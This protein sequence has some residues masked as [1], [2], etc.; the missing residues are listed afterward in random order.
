MLAMHMFE[1]AGIRTIKGPLH[2]YAIG[3][4]RRDNWR[5]LAMSVLEE[6]LPHASPRIV[7]L[8]WAELEQFI[9]HDLSGAA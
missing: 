2:W 4:E 7:K 8:A 3:R 9:P 5:L 1:Q 6:G